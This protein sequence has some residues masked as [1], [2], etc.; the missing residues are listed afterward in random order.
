MLHKNSIVFLKITKPQFVMHK[1]VHLS[2]IYQKNI[3][4]ENLFIY[5]HNVFSVNIYSKLLCGIIQISKHVVSKVGFG[6][7]YR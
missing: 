4:L 6:F 7:A 2:V 1:R 5:L 3:R